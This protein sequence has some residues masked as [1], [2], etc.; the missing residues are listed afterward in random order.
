MLGKMVSD[1]QLRRL[2]A[3]IQEE[4]PEISGDI[5]QIYL[6]L[7]LLLGKLGQLVCR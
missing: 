2:A 6:Y 5:T 1:M 4:L 3:T 7:Y